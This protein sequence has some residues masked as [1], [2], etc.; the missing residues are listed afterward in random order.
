MV[1]CI[2]PSSTPEWVDWERNTERLQCPRRPR[3]PTLTAKDLA[4]DQEVRW[5][6]GCG[7]YSILAQMKK[8]LAGLGIPREKMVF[9]SGIGCSSRFPYY[10]NTYGFHTHP[11]PGADVRHRPEGGPARPAGLGHHR[12]RRRP[13]DRRQPP[14]PRHPPQRRPQDHPVQQRN[15][16]PDQGP[17]LADLADRHAHQVEPAGLDRQPAAAAVARHRRRG[18]LRRPHHRRRRQ[19]PDRDAASGPPPTRAPPSS[20]SIRTARSSTTASSSTPPTRASRPTTRSTSST[21]SR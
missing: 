12:R 7:D 11:R 1:R 14:D 8:A 17:V 6:P 3:L 2:I 10:M 15:L 13:V 16:R 21:A 18:D 4:S 5:C 9:V 19:P 20:R